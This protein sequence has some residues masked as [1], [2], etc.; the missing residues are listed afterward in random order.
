MREGDV[1]DSVMVN[2]EGF[3]GLGRGFGL[4]DKGKFG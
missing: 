3:V 2:G 4:V 1:F